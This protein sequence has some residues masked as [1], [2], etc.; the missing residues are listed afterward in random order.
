MGLGKTITS[1]AV[2][3]HNDAYP[4]LIIA[5]SSLLGNW[6]RECEKWLPSKR[7]QLFLSGKTTL[8]KSADVV[9]V[10]YS[11]ADKVAAQMRNPSYGIRYFQQ[12]IVDEAHYIKNHKSQRSKIVREIAGGA[13]NLLLLSG[14]PISRAPKDLYA[15]LETLGVAGKGKAFGDW[16]AFTK[17]YC[18]GHDTKYGY[19]CDGATH[20]D[21]LAERLRSSIYLRREKEQV[22]SDLPEKQRQYLYVPITAEAKAELREI[23]NRRMAEINNGVKG[24]DMQAITAAFHAVGRGKIEAAEV[25]IE[26]FADTGKKL[27]VFANQVTLQ[28]RLFEKAKE[29]GLNPAKIQGEDSPMARDAAVQKFQSDPSCR[30]IVCSLKA[31]GVGVTLTAASDVLMV[32]MD[33]VPATL[34]QAEDRAH[35]IGQNSAVNVTYLVDEGRIDEAVADI[36]DGRRRIRC[37]SVCIDRRRSA[38]PAQNGLMIERWLHAPLYR[39]ILMS[40]KLADLDRARQLFPRPLES[41][42]GE[43]LEREMPGETQPAYTYKH[44]DFERSWAVFVAA[45][46]RLRAEFFPTLRVDAHVVAPFRDDGVLAVHEGLRTMTLTHAPVAAALAAFDALTE[47]AAA[48]APLRRQRAVFTWPW[49]FPA[50]FAIDALDGVHVVANIWAPDDFWGAIGYAVLRDIARS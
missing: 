42:A 3:H 1:L 39:R 31:A 40:K 15:Q 6:K 16:W 14:T 45:V 26:N 24:A 37:R 21:E 25:F 5:P 30:V 33:W 20:I 23:E 28:N 47:M 48:S 50:I 9:I 41:I 27:I 34:D 32:E 22:L 11:L 44:A 10:S 12:L 36:I 13:K 17:R 18:D 38:R 7:V 8:D 43:I 35:L 49:D 19:R 29:I 2:L 4:A 46:D